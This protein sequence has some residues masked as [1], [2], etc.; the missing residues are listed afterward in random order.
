[1][2]AASQ[3]QDSLQ[4][5]YFIIHTLHFFVDS[6][7]FRSGIEHLLADMLGDLLCAL[8]AEVVLKAR[9]EILSNGTDLY[10]GLCV[11]NAR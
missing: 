11:L 10:L 8:V 7:D 2:A 3:F 6:G 5:L 4:R 9:P 1:M